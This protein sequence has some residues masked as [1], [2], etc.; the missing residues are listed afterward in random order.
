MTTTRD[1]A[2]TE[3]K[4]PAQNGRKAYSYF[5]NASAAKKGAAG[6]GAALAVGGL[7]ATAIALRKKP[8]ESNALPAPVE[9]PVPVATPQSTASRVGEFAKKAAIGTGKTAATLVGSIAVNKAVSF[10]VKKA[11]SKIT[12][13]S[14]EARIARDRAEEAAA[15]EAY[16]Q[17]KAAREQKQKGRIIDDGDD[18]PLMSDAEVD[19]SIRQ[20]VIK[21]NR[22]APPDRLPSPKPKLEVGSALVPVNKPQAATPPAPTRLPYNLPAPKV[23]ARGLTIATGESD[24][25]SGN[26]IAKPQKTLLTKVSGSAGAALGRLVR[27]GKEGWERDRQAGGVSSLQDKEYD[28]NQLANR[29]GKGTRSAAESVANF[30]QSFYKTFV[31]DKNTV[32]ISA[33]EV[34][35]SKIETPK[36][37]KGV[38]VRALPQGGKRKAGRPKTKFIPK[39]FIKPED[40]RRDSLYSRIDSFVSSLAGR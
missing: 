10:A 1:D 30:A 7:A 14:S 8:E 26:A 35:E 34:K 32:D 16:E 40:K 25:N 37:I 24:K 33:T 4:V 23:S 13:E 17:R 36:K 20:S 19:E 18:T 9:A 29:A 6:V 38:T 5:R 15:E 21:A 11:A 27:K 2:Q 31:D 22:L 39:D 28:V 12:K 3:V